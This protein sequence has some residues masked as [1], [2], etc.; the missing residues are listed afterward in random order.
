MG[1]EELTVWRESP[2]YK[3]ISFRGFFS[4]LLGAGSLLMKI[5]AMSF[6]FSC[7]SQLPEMRDS[8][9]SSDSTLCSL[10]L[11]WGGALRTHFSKWTLSHH[12]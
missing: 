10:Q 2:L 5:C 6:V 4:C 11:H 12:W 1:G 9:C 3:D 8:C 7:A